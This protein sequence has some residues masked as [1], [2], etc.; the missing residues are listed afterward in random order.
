AQHPDPKSRDCREAVLLAISLAKQ[1]QQSLFVHHV[2]WS[3]EYT[4]ESRSRFGK[5][6]QLGFVV[7]P[8]GE[9]NSQDG[10]PSSAELFGGESVVI[11]FRFWPVPV[12]VNRSS[13]SRPI[14][15]SGQARGWRRWRG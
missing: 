6:C 13:S 1:W 3:G 9:V 11:Q 12:Y 14:S 2:D 7:S 4:P 15:Q 5:H 10:F 8:L